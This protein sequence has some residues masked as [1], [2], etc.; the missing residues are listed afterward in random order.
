MAEIWELTAGGS[1]LAGETPM[2]CAMRELREETGIIA[3][4][5]QKIQR[6]VHDGHRALYVEYW[7]VT[8]WDKDAVTL[9]K[10]KTADY[11][12]GGT[13]SL[14]PATLHFVNGVIY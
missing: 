3:S 8:D 6:F 12:W 7:C 14:S 1:V 11:Q 9:Q 10:G 13:R 2:E 5:L 4:D